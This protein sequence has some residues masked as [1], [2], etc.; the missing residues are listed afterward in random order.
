MQAHPPYS[1]AGRRALQRG[2]LIIAAAGN[3]AD[4][5]AGNYGFV[6]APA[7]SVEIM[8]VGALDMALGM[9]YFSARSLP[10]RGGQVDIAGP[11]WQVYS[12]WPMPTRY[13][14]ISGTSMA[15]P[16]VAGLAA[17][18]A[19]ATGR[20]G[21][22]L[23]ATLCT[24]S[25]RLAAA[26]ARRRQRAGAGAPV[27][28]RPR[29]RNVSG[30]VQLSVTVDDGHL[31]AINDVAAALRAQGMQVEQV[32]DGL[33][34]HHRLGACR[35]RSALTGVEGVAS[36]DEELTHQLPPPDSAVQ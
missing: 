26:V 5:R 1:A 34:D 11:G 20:R 8:A 27:R 21:L 19:E 31:P 6:G 10:A 13:R 16:H 9:A 18:W 28:P 36:V 12:S 25:E 15:T 30:M 23:W 24:E 29:R 32:L 4:R 22:E 3:N 14:T 33:G 35:R 7:N 2:S 17:L